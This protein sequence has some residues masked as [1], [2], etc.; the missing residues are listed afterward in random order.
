MT[1][2]AV[3]RTP[4]ADGH[5]IDFQVRFRNRIYL[6]DESPALSSAGIHRPRPVR[7]HHDA[8]TIDDDPGAD[9]FY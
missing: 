7:F 9:R 8:E 6:T 2:N 3:D 5:E 1:V 4:V